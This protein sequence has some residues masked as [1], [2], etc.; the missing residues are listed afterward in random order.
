MW[1]CGGR[2][3]GENVVVLRDKSGGGRR[4]YG[5]ADVLWK[6]WCPGVADVCR[7]E[8][9]PQANRGKTLH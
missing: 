1:L 7:K 5:S 8:N 6:G 2:K 4:E 9:E 3:E